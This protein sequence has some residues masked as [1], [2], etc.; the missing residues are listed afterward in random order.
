MR[1]T[2]HVFV[3]VCE[4]LDL[5]FDR[6]VAVRI[7]RDIQFVYLRLQSVQLVESALD[8]LAS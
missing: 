2:G 4:L 8:L 3:E 1:N 7:L 5:F 6:R